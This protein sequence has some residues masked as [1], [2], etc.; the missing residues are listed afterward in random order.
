VL[1]DQVDVDSNRACRHLQRRT[2]VHRTRPIQAIYNSVLPSTHTPVNI[3]FCTF[4]IYDSTSGFFPCR[5]CVFINMSRFGSL[6][7]QLQM[8]S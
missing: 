6:S 1:I 8:S 5:T 7:T 3:I 4:Q 2:S